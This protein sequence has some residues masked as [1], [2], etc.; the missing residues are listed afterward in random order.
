MKVRE[1]LVAAV[2]PGR[3]RGAK[4][5]L[6]TRASFRGA[7]LLLA[8]VLV[9]SAPVA[10]QSQFDW[11]APNGTTHFLGDTIDVRW[12]G[13]DPAWVVFIAFHEMTPGMPNAVAGSVG[14][15]LPNNGALTWTLPAAHPFGG[16][17]VHSYRLYVQQDPG[18]AYTYG[19]LFTAVC[20]PVSRAGADQSVAEG[21]LVTLDGG[22]ST[23]ETYAWEQL[24]GEP[25]TLSGETSRNPTFIPVL[26]GGT[27]NQTLTFRLTV[28]AGA[29]I[30]TD[31]VD[32]AVI[33][34]N[35][36]PVVDA[37]ADQVVQEGSLVALSGGYSFD[38][39]GDPIT[40]TWEQLA[41][42][43]VVLTPGDGAQTTFLAPFVTEAGTVVV[44]ATASD[45]V[46]S[47]SDDVVVTLENVNH[48]PVAAAGPDQTSDEGAVVTLDGGA[49]SDPD[50]DSL[51]YGWVQVGGPAV[52]LADPH[53]SSPT[54]IAPA[55][56]LGGATLEF[57]LA[58][59]DGVVASGPDRVTIH[60]ANANDPP[61]CV[62][63]RASSLV[64]W[65]PN[66]GLVRVSV[67]GVADPDDDAVAIAIT[68][69]TQDEPVDG[70]GDGDTGPDAFMDSGGVLLRAE[71]AGSGNGRVYRIAFSADDG[72]NGSCAGSVTV[73]V[74]P[75][76]RPGVV[77]TDDGQDYQSR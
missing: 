32:V 73:A 1:A 17:C 5:A 6:S 66:H 3:V 43:Q 26:P 48:P 31:T 13:G 76:M 72:E 4:R 12:S 41:G 24:A 30:S 54:F 58:V 46:L 8:F 20:I 36:A 77:A 45:G 40:I 70:L 63:A 19:P 47:A 37:G 16:P 49:S 60:V 2:I 61:V 9:H 21:T 59:S 14:H 11:I 23:G 67:A 28:R 64:I 29:R 62:A 39:D 53:A 50:A 56:D 69:I 42:P 15:L 38:P 34:A 27:V 65:P 52:S 35:H 55:V 25:V 71:R 57:D 68:G 33:N 51:T 7:L 22:A 75:S 18:P 10:A 44:R 74:P